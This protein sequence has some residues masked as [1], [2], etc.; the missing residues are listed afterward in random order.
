MFITGPDVIKTVT[1]ED[2]TFEELGGAITHNSVSGVAHLACE[3][4]EDMFESLR[5]LIS[6]VPQN[7][8]ESL[9]ILPYTKEE[10]MEF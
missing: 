6:Y 10:L 5:E 8:M 3:S 9:P 4:E 2:V 1:H 7:N